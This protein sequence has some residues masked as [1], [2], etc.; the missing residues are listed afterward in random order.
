MTITKIRQNFSCFS[1]FPCKSDE[2][3]ECPRITAE[4]SQKIM[5]SD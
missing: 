1:D 3:K 5:T 2:K 4:A